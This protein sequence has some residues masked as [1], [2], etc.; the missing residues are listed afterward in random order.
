MQN[1]SDS[2]LRL[3]RAFVRSQFP[4]FD[5]PDLQGQAHFENAGGSY[6]CHQVI[7]RLCTYYRQTKVQ[8]Y[9]S[10]KASALAGEQMD[11]AYVRLA[12]YLNLAPE[13]VHLGP[14]TSQNT[15]VLAQAFRKVL[16]PGDE[17]IVTN[18]DHEAN[19]GA[20]RRLADDGMVIREWQ[21]DPA[22]GLLDPDRLDQL[23]TERT[24]LLAFT[25]CSNVVGHINPV[26]TICHKARAAGIF[27]IVDGVSHAGH[28]FP[29]V[30]ALGADVYLFSLYK[31]FGPHQGVMTISHPLAELLGNQGHFFNKGLVHKTFNP[32]GPDHAQVAA[33]NGVA[34]YFDTLHAHHFGSGTTTTTPSPSVLA[35]AR[36]QQL[37]PLFREAET[38]LLV[39]LLDYL[40]SRK[41]VR[42]LGPADASVRA[43]T[44]AFVSRKHGAAALGAALSTH[45][46][47]AGAGHYYAWRCIEAMGEAPEAGVVRLSFVHYTT[48]EEL[49]QLLTAL[50]QVL[51]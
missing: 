40:S 24:R 43:A 33:S 29:D 35:A 42:L 23:F 6:V 45:N 44:V 17:I 3:D 4:A 28:G 36:A 20:W 25:H 9:Y 37:Q 22:S 32:A 39:P 31:T 46:I 19:I 7:E 2:R 48:P 8:P 5:E 47:M 1:P 50:D 10:F 38:E 12:E 13:T 14:S 11:Q 21:L 26:A 49:Q 18:Q 51:A 30:N 15:A 27:T 34:D 41:D 16:K